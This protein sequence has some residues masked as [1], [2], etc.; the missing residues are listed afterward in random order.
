M[1]VRTLK[2]LYH[3]NPN[4]RKDG[5]LL[6]TYASASYAWNRTTFMAVPYCLSSFQNAFASW[7]H[8]LQGGWPRRFPEPRNQTFCIRTAS[9]WLLQADR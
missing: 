5:L 3:E 6:T 8:I 9:R 1:T 4:L 7:Y 2:K